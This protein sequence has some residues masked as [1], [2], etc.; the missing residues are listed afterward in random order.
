MGSSHDPALRSATYDFC[1]GARDTL[2]RVELHEGRVLVRCS[3]DTFNQTRREAFVHE[4]AEEGFI[5]DDIRWYQANGFST[6]RVRWIIDISWI[7]LPS[8]VISRARHFMV[9]LISTAAVTW[10]AA[11]VVCFH[12]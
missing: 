10:L 3:R 6:P 9:R 11:L 5:P 12:F 4:L 2:V 1:F 7:E 8:V